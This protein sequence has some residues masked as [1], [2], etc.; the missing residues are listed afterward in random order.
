MTPLKKDTS[1]VSSLRPGS[2]FKKSR[3]VFVVLAVLFIH[4]K[5]SQSVEVNKDL[6][7]K[8]TNITS[9]E[10]TSALD[11]KLRGNE[12][13]CKTEIPTT[14]TP[15]RVKVLQILD[16]SCP[17]PKTDISQAVTTVKVSPRYKKKP[18]EK[19]MTSNHTPELRSQIK[20]ANT[21]P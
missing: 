18:R 19:K 13:S 5:T 12:L 14:S 20:E 10:T 11:L 4:P 7:N 1:L 9:P 21:I 16:S 17:L 8:P 2:S 6:A 15:S 3:L